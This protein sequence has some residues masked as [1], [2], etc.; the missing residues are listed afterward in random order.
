MPEKTSLTQK[1]FSSFFWRF[2]ENICAQLVSTCV[3]IVLARKLFPE[4]YG[5]VSIVE[6][7]IGIFSIF[8][9]SG[10]GS[11]LIQKRDADEVDYSSMF[12]FGLAMSGAMY[13]ILFF[14]APLIANF[15]EN[16]L[17]VPVLRVLGL[18][19]PLA[20][21]N[22]IQNAH[23]AKKLAYRKSFFVTIIGTIISAVVGIT[24]AYGGF[25]VWALVAQ[26]M[27][28]SCIDTI[29]LAITV[30]WYPKLKFS[31]KRTKRLFSFGSK[32]LLDSLISSGYGH[33]RD[34][35]V[36]KRYSLADLAYYQKSY[37]YPRMILNTV[38]G[39]VVSIAFPILSIVQNEID[40]LKRAVKNITKMLAY[41]MFPCMVGFACIAQNFVSVVLTDKWLPIV[42]MMQ[43]A[44]IGFFVYPI[45]GVFGDLIKSMGKSNL[46]LKISIVN[47]IINMVALLISMWF[48]IFWIAV[49]ELFCSI[50]ST[51]MGVVAYKKLIGY[52]FKEQLRDILPQMLLS[53]AM[54]AIVYGVGFIP[55]NKVALLV[56]QIAV[57]IVVYVLGSIVFKMEAFRFT[58]NTLTS[59]L[60]S[61]KK[62]AA[63][64]ATEN[65][66]EAAADS[67]SVAAMESIIEGEPL[68]GAENPVAENP[69]SNVMNTAAEP[70]NANDNDNKSD[71]VRIDCSAAERGAKKG[72]AEGSTAE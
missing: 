11:A 53:L 64:P 31:F 20:H 24:M 9:S 51:I 5:V 4:D 67:A 62:P 37:H 36:G 54:G 7:F 26:Y 32:I 47:T 72:K 55:I 12:Y 61:R 21:L 68:P 70:P 57:G 16:Q 19:L 44:C 18:R 13:A 60:K 50:K 45:G 42:G 23:I 46:L 25:G 41:L 6:M 27:T 30:R 69:C 58:L 65:A 66:A 3:G 28:N 59:Y 17:L 8:V 56:L 52:G 43:I 48:G 29:A 34:F 15:Y 35:F 1:A 63:E 33:F 49:S 2:G 40:R 14:T 38:Q 22:S 39:V 71:M 10:M